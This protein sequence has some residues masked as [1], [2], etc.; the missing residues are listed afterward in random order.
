MYALA[1]QTSR[2]AL[3]TCVPV[4]MAHEPAEENILAALA[5]A[6]FSAE[7]YE[8]IER[9]GALYIQPV[10]QTGRS[11]AAVFSPDTRARREAFAIA[12]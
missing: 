9:D 11:V 10:V 6:L 7:R 3:D 8:L 2:Q 5:E 4:P 12:A 1:T